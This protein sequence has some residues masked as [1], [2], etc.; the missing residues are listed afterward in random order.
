MVNGMVSPIS[1][2][3]LVLLYRN[4]V[5]LCL[6]ILYPTTL[7]TSLM[8]CNSFLV[9]F[10]VFSSIVSCDLQTVIVLLLLFQFGFLL[11]IFLLL[12]CLGL[13]KLCEYHWWEWA[14]LSCSWSLQ[15]Y[16]Q[17]FTIEND[18]SCGFLIHGFYYGEVI[19]LYAHSLGS[20]S[21]E[22]VLNFFQK[23]FFICWTDHVGFFFSVCWYGVS[24][25]LICRYWRIL[26]SWDKSQL[27]MVYN[28]F[29]SLLGPCSW[30]MEVLRLGN[31]ELYLPAYTTA[32]A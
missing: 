15:K 18:V 21:S 13:P 9:M 10:L 27:I 23:F 20:F 29:F 24:H 4:A 2:S 3:D 14:S 8:S 17:F 6:L 1:L 16:F 30:H 31:K 32:I 19:P 5:N 28:L 12:L 7:P 11:F 22:M 26:A 25:W